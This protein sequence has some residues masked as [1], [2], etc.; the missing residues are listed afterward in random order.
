MM[1]ASHAFGSTSFNLAVP[2][3]EYMKAARCPSVVA[4]SGACA[5]LFRGI[6]HARVQ[7]NTVQLIALVDG[8]DWKRVRPVTV[9]RPETIG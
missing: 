6:G 1:F 4:Y 2:I 3:K 5:H 7:L 8:L 9:R